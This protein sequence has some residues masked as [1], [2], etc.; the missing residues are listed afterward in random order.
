MLTAS[1]GAQ[2]QR[3][4]E[5]ASDEARGSV[6]RGLLVRCASGVNGP[7]RLAKPRQPQP[8]RT[9]HSARTPHLCSPKQLTAS[10]IASCLPWARGSVFNSADDA[11]RLA[12]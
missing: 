12:I 6:A 3:Q 10:I 1:K 9:V 2:R 8:P 11:W 7:G 4:A 5:L